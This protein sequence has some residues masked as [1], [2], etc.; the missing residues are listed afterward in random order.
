MVTSVLY[1][2]PYVAVDTHVHRVLNRLGIV[3]TKNPLETDKVVDE[4]FPKKLK[5]LAHHP[6]VLFGRYFCTAKK[7][8]CK[9]CAI[10]DKCQY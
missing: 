4:I 3:D 9:E 5:L 2:E 6:L 1:D 7:P 8:K 10:R